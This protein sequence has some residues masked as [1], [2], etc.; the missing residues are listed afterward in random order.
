MTGGRLYAIK[1][2]MKW[3]LSTKQ[4]EVYV[5]KR[6][7][8]KIFPQ[9]GYYFVAFFHMQEE[10]KRDDVYHLFEVLRRANNMTKL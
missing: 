2:R 9:E 1:L 3:L 8:V 10:W 7:R 5:R 4:R 6:T